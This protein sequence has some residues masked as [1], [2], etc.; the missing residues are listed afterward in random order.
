[1]RKL[2]LEELLSGEVLEVCLARWSLAHADVVLWLLADK[3]QDTDWIGSGWAILDQ[4][5]AH[6]G[7]GADGQSGR[8]R[9]R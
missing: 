2:V 5:S 7:Q 1:V 9:E 4:P 3:C 6:S 8:T